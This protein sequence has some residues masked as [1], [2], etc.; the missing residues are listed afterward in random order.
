V[1][2]NRVAAEPR[3]DAAVGA[4]LLLLVVVAAKVPVLATPYY[5]D[6]TL[7]IGF[8]HQLAELHLWQVLPGL[9]PPFLFGN[10]LPGI[11]LPMAA[12]FKLTGPS[13]VVSH[14]LIVVFAFL[15]VWFT[16]LLGRR[17]FGRTAGV[18]AA[19]FLFAS[20]LYFAQSAMFLADLPAAATAVAAVYFGVERRFAPYWAC[21][22]YLVLL[23]E[24]VVSVVCALA[25]WAF[26]TRVRA[27]FGAAVADA[28]RYA[29]PVAVVALYYLWQWRATGHAFVHYHHPFDA[30]SADLDA[31]L[32]QLPR[33]TRWL[34]AEQGRWAFSLV[35]LAAFVRRSFRRRAELLLV[36]LIVLGAGY[37]YALLYFLPRYLLPVAPFFFVA[38][39]GAL[40]EL[41]RSQ[42]VR[43]TAGVVLIATLLAR[44]EEHPG[45][46]NR[47]HDL[48]YLRVVRIHR[49]AAGFLERE[50]PGAPVR[51]GFPFA[52]IL[53]RPELGYVRERREVRFGRG[54]LDDGAELIVAAF[55]GSPDPL[56]ADA[57]RR[58][59]ERLRR[60]GEGDLAVT[61]YS[62]ARTAT[63]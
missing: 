42:R 10:R 49:E 21:A 51:A 38:S 37:G 39:A 45:R 50:L 14:A 15:G 35:L 54:D 28:A 30:F 34:F 5:W 22:T 36:A 58:G 7:W 33:I 48:G 18:L 17:W 26:L 53:A 43:L 46:G 20:P 16:F 55:P 4:G 12:V 60:F 29:A 3:W 59:L 25:L 52:Q 8:A 57:E 63:P 1:E 23:K 9:H 61:I 2:A 13:I 32:E 47:E 40:V 19:L 41:A 24:P 27:S 56:A 11:F 44:L 62:G 31:A 6:E